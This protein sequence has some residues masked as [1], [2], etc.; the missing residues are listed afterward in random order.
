MRSRGDGRR[1]ENLGV[2]GM[3]TPK[4]LRQVKK[5][6]IEQVLGMTHYDEH[7]AAA[8]LELSVSSLRRLMGRLQISPSNTVPI[9]NTNP[10][11]SD[12]Q[13]AICNDCEKNDVHAMILNGN[14][15]GL[16]VRPGL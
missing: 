10:A 1:E 6:H 11:T 13:I 9:A 3:D 14:T 4:P 8:L 12:G 5:H 15:E 16:R 2:S 7:Q